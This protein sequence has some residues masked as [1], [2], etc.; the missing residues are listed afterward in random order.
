MAVTF[1]LTVILPSLSITIPNQRVTI[2]SH[3][4]NNNIMSNFKF[5]TLQLHAG[6]EADPT[7]GSRAGTS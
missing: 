5:E 3:T 7:T 6:Q 2:Q 4:L 1:P